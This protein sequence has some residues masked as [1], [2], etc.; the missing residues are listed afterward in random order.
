MR[1]RAAIFYGVFLV[2]SVS[3]CGSRTQLDA[4]AGHPK[5]AAP[6]VDAP[7]PIDAPTLPSCAAKTPTVLL[8]V[9]KDTTL[10]PMAQDALYLYVVS[11]HVGT[12]DILRVSKCDGAVKT[13]QT[14][15]GYGDGIAV[16][17]TNVYFA[18]NAPAIVS[19][20]KIGGAITQL[21]AISVAVGGLALRDGVLYFLHQPSSS[22]PPFENEVRSMPVTGGTTTFVTIGYEHLAVDDHWV[23]TLGHDTGNS[24]IVAAAK[25]GG[26]HV[27]LASWWFGG[28]LTVADDGVYFGGQD[29]QTVVG[30]IDFAKV[31]SPATRFADNLEYVAAIAVDAD[32]VY[33]TDADINANGA[34]WRWSKK[35]GIATKLA[36]A[37]NP[38][39]GALLVDPTSIF[40][41]DFPD[42]L[43]KLDKP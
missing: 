41:L 42:T 37:T 11:E 6:E 20:P 19:T 22:T 14:V 17:D 24:R 7:S 15:A 29:V 35:G 27:D 12:V 16:D 25:E 13:L 40:W 4:D 10:G 39:P 8:K 31:G 26:A 21:G 33:A 36:D 3:G 38:Y 30:S 28:P 9:S 2:A 34:L 5:D 23:Y 32:H 18:T 1:D 43:W